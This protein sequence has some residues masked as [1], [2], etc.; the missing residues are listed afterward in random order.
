MDNPSGILTALM[1]RVTS[2]DFRGRSASHM[3]ITHP[4]NQ[5]LHPLYAIS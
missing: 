2:G 5:Q 3:H 4:I 1:R